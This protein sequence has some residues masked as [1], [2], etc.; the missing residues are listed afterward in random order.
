MSTFGG[1]LDNLH[2]VLK[3]DLHSVHSVWTVLPLNWW[4]LLSETFSFDCVKT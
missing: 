4:L 3:S 2:T 1:K